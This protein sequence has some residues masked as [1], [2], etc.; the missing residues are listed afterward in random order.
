MT[1]VAI[2]DE[3]LTRDVAPP[4]VSRPL[5]TITDWLIRLALAN[6]CA[7][8]EMLRTLVLDIAALLRMNSDPDTVMV[9]ALVMLLDAPVTPRVPT[10]VSVSTLWRD[11]DARTAPRPEA[12]RLMPL[13]R[14]AVARTV[15][16]ALTVRDGMLRS[17]ALADVEIGPAVPNIVPPVV[18][19]AEAN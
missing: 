13:D 3:P 10:A 6:N 12:V 7:A 2:R 8:P 5:I 15:A 18:R 11:A 16:K 14:A 17:A 4:A 1:P 19:F 9:M